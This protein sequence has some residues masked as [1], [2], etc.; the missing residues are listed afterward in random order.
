MQGLNAKCM[1]SACTIRGTKSPRNPDPQ[2]ETVFQ[3][4][5]SGYQV[6]SQIRH[7]SM[8]GLVKHL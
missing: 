4:K 5:N 7:F 3:S 8:A 6:M 2:V 1:Y